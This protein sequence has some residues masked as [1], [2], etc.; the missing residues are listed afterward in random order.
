[1]AGFHRN[2][3]EYPAQENEYQGESLGWQE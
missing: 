3:T 2:L 1:M